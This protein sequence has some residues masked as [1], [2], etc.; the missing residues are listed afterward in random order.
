MKKIF[1]IQDVKTM[2]YFCSYRMDERFN[3]SFDDAE[4]FKSKE[5]ALIRISN[6]YSSECFE[7]R[8]I[9]IK[10]LFIIEEK[11]YDTL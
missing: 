9:E 10:E 5:I 7:G 2:E 1:V 11:Q 6:E 4:N 3:Q 8:T